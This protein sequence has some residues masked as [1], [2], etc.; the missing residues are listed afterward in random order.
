MRTASPSSI[1][2]RTTV[3]G[4]MLQSLPVRSEPV[5]YAPAAM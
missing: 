2:P 5:T 4:L 3:Y 1:V